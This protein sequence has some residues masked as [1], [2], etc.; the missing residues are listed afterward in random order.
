MA[1]STYKVKAGDSL[2]KI[3]KELGVPIS[4]ISGYKSGN[5][6][7]IQVGEV[8]TI[9]ASAAPIASPYVA[10]VIQ[11]GQIDLSKVQET[12][13]FA[14]PK[15]NGVTVVKTEDN[16]DGTTT[17]Y[18]S[19]GSTDKGKYTRNPDGTLNFVPVSDPN[20]MSFKDVSFS[21]LA[22]ED[23]LSQ[24]A[25]GL[26][27]EIAALEEKMANRD[28]DRNTALEDADV[29]NDMKRLN[30]LKTE[31]RAAED[32]DI[33]IPIEAR[34]KLRGNQATKT[35]FSQETRPKLEDNLLRTLAATRNVSA[36]TDTI[37]TNIAVIDSKIKAD[38][39]RDEFLYTQ[40]KDRLD[41]VE[42]IYGNIITEKQKA[43]IEEKKMMWD[44]ELENIKSDNSLRNDLIKGLATRG[45]SGAQL[46]GIMNASI[47]DLLNLSYSSGL[48]NSAR[49]GEMTYEEAAMTLSKEDFDK[50]KV[51]KEFEKTATDEEKKAGAEALALTQSAKS[52]VDLLESMLNDKSGLK[53]S[54]GFGLGNMD[55]S[56]LGVGVESAAFRANAKQ[57]M[58]Q[59]TLD[60]L[61]Q[62][63]AAGGTLGAISEKE[64]D[65]LSNA[66]TALGAV[67]DDNGKATGRFKF[68]EEDFKT[69]LETMRIAAM[70]TYIA[71]S[72]GKDAF[73]RAGYQ[74]ADFETINKRYT[75][76]KTTG[77]TPQQDY[78]QTD[79]NSVAPGLE[80]AFNTIK[81]SE[82]FRSEAYQDQTGKWTIGFGNTT[83]GGRPVQPG[84]RLSAAQ[85]EALMQ[86]SIVQNYT[87]FVDKITSP[88]TPNQFAAL[89]SFEYNLGSGVWD[90]PTGQ[91]ILS[92]VDQKKFDAAGRLMLQFNKSR[93]PRTGQLAVNNGLTNRRMKEANLLL[94]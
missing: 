23:Q 68:K 53:S 76:L 77:L 42:E 90:Q 78:Y 71:G 13:P 72:I 41:K 26:R 4:S 66:A 88:L 63:K 70:K 57:L 24:T 51:Y 10:P 34:Q 60:K 1:T 61:L 62:L 67:F 89:T 47:D 11:N 32:R 21:S 69:A 43:A 93:D 31:L 94:T 9:G 36:M 85:S 87:K 15:Q 82:G 91:Q 81:E 44:L 37:N 20:G 75:D 52:T 17:N 55:F 50:Y 33:E 6:D 3:A 40:K 22:P 2:S 39:A 30:E 25:V 54:V 38:T 12:K 46:G 29:F 56:I 59:A 73:S 80:S 35:E 92:L 86:S 28:A 27:N 7:K 48:T 8:L 49:W 14:E 84:D 58:S 83:I 64:L 45:I 74:N 79:R 19:N 5:A 65:I 18:L 16:P